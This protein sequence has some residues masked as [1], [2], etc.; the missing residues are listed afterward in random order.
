MGARADSDR[1]WAAPGRAPVARVRTPQPQSRWPDAYAD[2]RRDLAVE[3]RPA[4][5]SSTFWIAFSTRGTFPSDERNTRLRHRLSDSPE[6]ADPC[7]VLCAPG[8]QSSRRAKD[9]SWR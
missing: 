8:R 2:I 1:A 7:T 6:T 3:S 5:V 4:P 9:A